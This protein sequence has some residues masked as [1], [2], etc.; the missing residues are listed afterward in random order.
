MLTAGR[1]IASCCIVNCINTLVLLVGQHE[2]ICLASAMLK[3]FYWETFVVTCCRL[4]KVT[5]VPVDQ[6]L[7]I[8]LAAKHLTNN[9]NCCT[10]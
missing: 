1:V 9:L 8:I 5:N 2:A 10:Q 3:V 7:K 6:R 4:E